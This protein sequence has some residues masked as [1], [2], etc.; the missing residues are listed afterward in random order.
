M[1]GEYK[2]PSNYLNTVQYLQIMSCN[3]KFLVKNLP[4]CV[5]AL[6]SRSKTFAKGRKL[7]D[8]AAHITPGDLHKDAAVF[9]LYFILLIESTVW[10]KLLSLLVPNSSPE[11]IWHQHWLQTLIILEGVDFGAR[12]SLHVG[13][14]SIWSVFCHLKVTL[15]VICLK[16]GRR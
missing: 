12:A 4:I 10:K 11:A 15:S 1:S 6:L 7:W 8:N 16:S 14:F 2:P 13:T 5:F 3:S 9:A